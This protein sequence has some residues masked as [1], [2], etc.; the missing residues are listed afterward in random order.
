[1]RRRTKQYKTDLITNSALTWFQISPRYYQKKMLEQSQEDSTSYFELGSQIHMNILEPK[2]FSQ[3]F[4]YVDYETPANKQQEGFCVSYL[5]YNS[6]QIDMDEDLKLTQAY[7]DNYSATGK[8]PEKII[9]IAKDMYIKLKSYIEFLEK[10][11]KYKVVLNKTTW[12]LIKDT[13]QA[14]K[15]HSKASELLFVD[16]TISKNEFQ[17]EWEY[18]KKFN[19]TSLKCRSTLDRFV[20]DEENKKILLIYV[21]NTSNLA[22]FIESFDKYSYYRQLAFYWMAIH[23]EFKDKYNLNEYKVESYI[24]AIQTRGLVECKVFSISETDLDKGWKEISKLMEKLSWHI[25]EDKWDYSK[26]YYENNGI[27]LL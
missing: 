10:S 1:M 4:A 12:D 25:K 21:K 13:K 17:I 9:E 6:S 26:E 3:S 7:K 2:L 5:T 18:P 24:V 15:Q 19:D 23:E 16:K 14:V 27:E 8:S 20:L 22:E 11:K